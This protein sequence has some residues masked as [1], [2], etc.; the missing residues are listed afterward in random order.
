[1]APEEFEYAKKMVGNNLSNFSAWHYRTK[2]I[3]RLLNEKSASD[4]ERKKMLDDGKLLALAILPC[5]NDDGN[6][7]GTYT[8]RTVRPIRSISL[9]LPPEFDEHV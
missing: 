6:R 3:Q 8:S 7:I 5:V 1:M 4:E 2:L 9:V